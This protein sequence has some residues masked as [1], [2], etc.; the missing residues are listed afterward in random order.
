[1]EI[2]M[3]IVVKLACLYIVLYIVNLVWVSTCH[4]YLATSS[5]YNH[6]AY[7]NYNFFMTDF[8][9]CPKRDIISTLRHR[10]TVMIIERKN[11]FPLFLLY[12]YTFYD[13]ITKISL[14]KNRRAPSHRQ[15]L[16]KNIL[17]TLHSDEDQYYF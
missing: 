13:G 14:K 16:K 8:P 10:K 11:N 3:P 5:S 12:P 9:N 6:R 4:R 17:L 1:L 2:T 15:R 7:I